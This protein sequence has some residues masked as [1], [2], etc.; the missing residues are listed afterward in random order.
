[1]LNLMRNPKRRSVQLKTNLSEIGRIESGVS[2]KTR[3]LKRDVLSF[4]PIYLDN[5]SANAGLCM[6]RKI[7]SMKLVSTAYL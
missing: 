6:W 2:Y 1:M 7:L 4:F 5:S 3:L